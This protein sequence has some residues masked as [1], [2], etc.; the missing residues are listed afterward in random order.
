M[1]KLRNKSITIALPFLVFLLVLL[2]DEY[3]SLLRLFPLCPFY[4]AYHLYC[5]ACGNTRSTI[6]LLNGDLLLSLRYN[7]IPFLFA[8]FATGAYLEYAFR[9]FGRKVIILPRKGSFYIVGLIFFLLYLIIRNFI[10][11]PD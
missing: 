3:I 4:K 1:N 11:F 10:P 2:R 9:S 8:L 7:I 5:P 6:A